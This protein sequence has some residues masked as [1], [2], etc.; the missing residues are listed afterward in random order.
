MPSYATKL[1]LKEPTGI[2]TSNLASLKTE[3]DKIDV[4]KLRTAPVDLSKIS[5]VV[6]N[7][8]KK[9]VYDKLV[10]KVSNID[11]SGFF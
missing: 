1:D 11:A 4:E 9:T 7:V 10:T 8:V 2:D 6:N 5:N 3:I